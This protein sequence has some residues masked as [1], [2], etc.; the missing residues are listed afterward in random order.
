M[1]CRT[2]TESPML[3]GQW[4]ANS[5]NMP[6]FRSTT[7][8]RKSGTGQGSGQPIVTIC[9]S[10]QTVNPTKCGEETLHCRSTSR[11]SPFW[12]PLWGIQL[13]CKPSSPRK[14]PNTQVFSR[15]SVRCKICSVLGSCSCFAL[16]QEQTTSFKFFTLNT[17]SISRC[18]MTLESKGASNSC[19]TSQ[20][21]TKCGK[22]P[23]CSSLQEVWACGTPRDCVPRHIGPVWLALFQWC[24]AMDC[25]T[26]GVVS[27]AKFHFGGS[28]RVSDTL[29]VLDK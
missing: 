18:V 17:A 15:G 1:F 4:N 11:V 5:G 13:L 23:L 22:W 28:K 21:S 10:G 7:E 2:Q 6:G 29:A 27:V 9:F 14:L 8:R 16:N 26:H 12:E 25:R 19:C 20:C 24:G 3:K